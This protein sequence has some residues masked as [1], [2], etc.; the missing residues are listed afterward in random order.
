[1]YFN[2]LLGEILI[3]S[4]VALVT[5]IEECS[6][7][8]MGSVRLHVSSAICWYLIGGITKPM[9]NSTKIKSPDY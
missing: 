4:Y 6:Y 5:P 8:M 1:M 2:N 7:P 3:D 9:C